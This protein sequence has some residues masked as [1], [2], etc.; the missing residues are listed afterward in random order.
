LILEKL[1]VR[2]HLY[3][4][5]F[6][7]FLDFWIIFCCYFILR[8]FFHYMWYLS[9]ESIVNQC[10]EGKFTKTI[11][12][13][14]IKDEQKKCKVIS[15]FGSVVAVVFQNNFSYRNASKW[16][17]FIF[18]KLFL[19]SSHQNYQKHTKNKFLTNFFFKYGF[20]RVSKR[21]L[22]HSECL[23]CGEYSFSE[24]FLN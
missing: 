8:I 10:N 19:R 6:L 3:L 13:T 23:A 22:N 18:L 12:A 9:I 7:S 2:S 20:H 21:Y 14:E 16:Y 17:F 1:S 11:T 4:S 5:L 24:M 15:L